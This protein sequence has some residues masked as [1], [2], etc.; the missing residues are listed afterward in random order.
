MLLVFVAFFTA[1][2][3]YVISLLVEPIKHELGL[4]DVEVGL[5]NTSVLYAAYALFCIPMG[6]LVDRLNRVRMLVGAVALWCVGLTLTGLSG[7]LWLLVA[8]KAVLGLANAIT[9]PTSMSL[10]ADYFAPDRRAMATSTYGVGQGIGQ[11]GAI[12]VGGMGFGALTKLVAADPGALFGLTPWRVVSLAFALAGVLLIPLLATI[13][14]PARMEVRQA[15][16]G[17]FREIWAFRGFL[18]PL[19]GGTMFLSGMSTGVLSW[20][21]PALTRL[22]GQQPGDF[23]GWF[24]AVS[25][26]SSVAGILAGG[27][28]VDRVHRRG[29]RGRVMRPAAIAALLCVPASFMAVMPNLIWFALCAMLFTI[30]YAVAISIPVIAIN[31]R[32][33]NEL[34][35]AV[36]GLYVVTVAVAGAAAAPLVAVAGKM[37]GGDAMLGEGMAVI[38]APF[39]LLAALCFWRTSRT[40]AEPPGEEGV[41]PDRR[42]GAG[43]PAYRLRSEPV[44]VQR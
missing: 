33:P 4:T 17:T 36:M 20:I 3:I 27:K 31:F 15:G 43:D 7:G 28:L 1:M 30:A 42:G 32:I 16:G 12:L 2:D 13:R 34:R 6:M 22:Y 24:S 19:L 21:P 23:A 5:A 37:L 39:A 35:G 25:L 10:L 18:L 11:A 38:G 9:L 40:D 26:V 14:E 41:A 8:S 29:G 44:S